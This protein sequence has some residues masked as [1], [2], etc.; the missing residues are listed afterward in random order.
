MP[1]TVGQ[2]NISNSLNLHVL[3]LWEEAAHATF[4]QK[5]FRPPNQE[6]EP[7]IFLL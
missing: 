3:A 2:Y 6:I 1:N 4:T 5:E 7:R